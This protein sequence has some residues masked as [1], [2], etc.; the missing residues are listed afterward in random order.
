MVDPPATNVYEYA[1]VPVATE[2]GPVSTTPDGPF[3]V[4][5]T[6]VLDEAGAGLTVPVT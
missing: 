4:T 5:T 1:P 6:A 3:V 2:A